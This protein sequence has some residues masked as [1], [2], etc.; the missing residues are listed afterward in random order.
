MSISLGMATGSAG[1]GSAL[2]TRHTNGAQDIEYRY[3]SADQANTDIGDLVHSSISLMTTQVPS[4]PTTPDAI[5]VTYRT[6]EQRTAIRNALSRNRQRVHLVPETEATLAYLR[7]T[8]E[9]AQYSTVAIVDVGASGTAV[10]I[11]DQVDG[12]VLHSTR[13]SAVS[14]DVVDKLLYDYAHNALKPSA[15]RHVDEDRLRARCRGAKEQLS[16]DS[17][18]F[19]D[20]EPASGHPVEIT[21][22][23]FA[24]IIAPVVRDLTNIVHTTAANASHAPQAIALVG[25]GTRIP[26][27]ARTMSDSFDARIIAIA[28]PET[29]TAKGA[30]LLASTTAI[31]A[32][33]LAGA[34]ESVGA[35]SA[36]KASGALIGVLVVG[37]LVLTYGVRALTPS[38]DPDISPAGTDS[39]RTTTEQVSTSSQ[40]PP[41]SSDD[42]VPNTA[43]SNIIVTTTVIPKLPYSRAADPLP[44][45]QDHTTTTDVP[46]STTPETTPPTTSTTPTTPGTDPTQP[47]WPGIEWPDI[48]TF[49]PEP[50]A[51]IPPAQLPQPPAQE[52]PQSPSQE[53]GLSAPDAQLSPPPEELF[54]PPNMPATAPGVVP[55]GEQ[56]APVTTTPPAP[57]AG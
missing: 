22:G 12:T 53:P 21:A 54:L 38:A 49:W 11:V 16:V 1:V 27:L 39:V 23:T 5:A 35:S 34:G 10:S 50:P 45:T 32:Y 48:P 47:D 42:P 26:A 4:K 7:H 43:E 6:E 37:G 13:T 9:V 30:A 2:L 17:T 52:T 29:A 36:A 28:E 20:T 51:P 57:P 46:T 14:G 3:V 41:T 18:A 40:A 8:G 33:P 24:D 31:A 56:Q 55:R 44:T 25:G 19:V 15:R